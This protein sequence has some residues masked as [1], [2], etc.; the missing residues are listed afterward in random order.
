MSLAGRFGLAALVVF[1]LLLPAAGQVALRKAMDNDGDGFAD[2]YIFRPSDATWYILRS[3]GT[4]AVQPFGIANDDYMTPGD[5]DG[6]GKGDI[7]VWRDSDGSWYRLNSHD[8][9]FVIQGWGLSGDEPVARDFDGDGRTDFAVVRKSGGFLTWYVFR[10]NGS[11]ITTTTWGLDS[12]FIAPGDYDGDGK[13]D[14]AVQRP[15]ATDTSPANFYILTTA[16]SF[17]Q[18]EWGQSKDL[19]VPGD[20]DG[21]TR[22]DIAVVREGSTPDQPLTWIIRR[23]SDLGTTTIGWGLTGT[24]YTA[25]ND[26]DGD[27]R[28][29]F[30]VW[31]NSDG[32]FYELNSLNFNVNV[33]SWGLP[34]DYPVATYD[35]H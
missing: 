23:S 2:Y 20:Y 9:T 7:S 14:Y 35:T 6:D 22:T 21:D 17:Q 8:A 34:N 15:G 1:N 5:Y 25:Q 27:G 18:V 31:R 19:V 26:Y 12:D 29:D 4:I 3:G 32:K 16:G 11:G 30:A 28:T 10:I 33:W 24:D 13:F